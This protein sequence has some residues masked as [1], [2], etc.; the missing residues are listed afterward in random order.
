VQ[1]INGII[2]GLTPGFHMWLALALVA[3]A[4]IAYA[5]DRIPLEL[6]SLGILVLLAVIFHVFPLDD[7]AGGNRLG[8]ERIFAGFA[9]P[10]LIAVVSLLVL[11]QGLVRTGALEAVS[12]R[13]FRLG[14][15]GSATAI[16]ISL[17]AALVIS[18]FLNNTPVVVMMI[19]ILVALSNQLG[20]PTEKV[21]IPLSYAA[22]LGGMTTLI[23]SSTNLLVSGMVAELGEDPLRFFDF[24]IPGLVLAGIGLLYVLF[25][26]PRLLGERPGDA[27]DEAD[28]AGRQFIAQLEVEPA[29]PLVDSKPVAGMLP[30]L[31]GMTVL[32]VQ[33]GFR[34]LL[35]PFEEL[36]IRPRDV[37]I[38]AA[39]RKV[40]VNALARAHGVQPLSSTRD[41]ETNAT[42]TEQ[43]MAEAVVA[44]AS[45]LV[46][47]KLS[48]LNFRQAYGCRLIGIQR[49][50]RMPRAQINDIRLDAGDVLL[51]QG[52]PAD[53]RALRESHDVLVL[54]WS[55]TELPSYHHA[56]RAALIFLAVVVAI[57]SGQ[58]PTAIAAFAGAVLMIATG[59]LNIRQAVRAIDRVIVLLI[60]SAI[61]LGTMLYETGGAAYLAHSLTDL[62]FWM[63]PA[64]V[65]SA[66]FLLVACFT[67]LLSN[68]ACAVLFT[69]IAIQ[70]A[71]EL[72]V[73]PFIFVVAVVLAANCSFATPIGYLTNLLVLTPG[74]YRFVDFLRAGTPLIVLLW[75]G[76][77]IFA[78]WY[79]GLW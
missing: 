63:G 35:P 50:A 59:C 54:E 75:I 15:F 79:Y 71:G 30:Q 3:A 9:N 69:P 24:T 37:V 66:F 26:A 5:Q 12:Q 67:N 56:Q 20:R 70:V 60:A 1:E 57:A 10:A 41:G 32:M 48:Q 25:V 76:F 29:S 39:T 6:A 73:D 21:L 11:G 22:I 64:Y 42:R 28:S 7:G 72:G 58:V 13:L 36:V 33:R 14:R 40:L 43:V 62:L 47:R 74:R 23:G 51:I 34:T 61:A 8:P 77:S 46:G 68:Q 4:V 44:P 52:R 53:V 19:P 27:K 45:L 65:L 78:P 38:V 2:S 16:T 49:H 55:A 31:R 18:G 17:G